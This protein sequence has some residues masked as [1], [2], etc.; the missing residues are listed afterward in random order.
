MFTQVETRH[1]KLIDLLTESSRSFELIS[2]FRNESLWLSDADTTKEISGLLGQHSKRYFSPLRTAF[3][4][5]IK[6]LA[7]LTYFSPLL[8]RDGALTLLKFFYDNPQP[9]NETLILI[10]NDK[11][12]TLV[13][14]NWVNNVLTYKFNSDKAFNY[15]S[16]KI[17][18]L[19]FNS[20]FGQK[21]C[22]MEFISTLFCDLRA[23]AKNNNFEIYFSSFFSE[24][25]EGILV[26]NELA[27][28]HFELFTETL[29]LFNSL[30]IIKTPDE[31]ESENFTDFLFCDLNE[32]SFYYSDSYF[33]HSLLSHGAIDFTNSTSDSLPLV[34]IPLSNYHKIEIF[35][36]AKTDSN[37]MSAKK[38]Q[39]LLSAF[40]DSKVF[41]EE[42]ANNGS[43][44]INFTNKIYSPSFEDF[45]YDVIRNLPV[46]GQKQ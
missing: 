31:F 38:I 9:S 44:E 23:K 7:A 45:A 30:P 24:N 26:R 27:K 13:P 15:S 21:H 18:I 20:Q 39:N 17:K 10:I 5:E 22:S 36:L 34:T 12:K 29:R 43:K 3:L 41:S 14:A 1:S 33:Y 28:H 35:E 6:S 8:V 11:L 4:F 42:L 40:R 37:I 32:F 16:D 19:F 2:Q 46:A 25:P